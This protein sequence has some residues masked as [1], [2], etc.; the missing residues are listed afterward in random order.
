M[1]SLK[2]SLNLGRVTL[3]FQSLEDFHPDQLYRNFPALF[4]IPAQSVEPKVPSANLLDEIVQ[5]QSPAPLLSEAADLRAFLDRAVRPHLESR[6]DQH[7]QDHAAASAQHAAD[8]MSAILHHASFQSIEA[9]WQSLK[10]LIDRLQ[11]GTGAQIYIADITLAELRSGAEEILKRLGSNWQLIISDYRF[12]QTEPDVQLLTIFATHAQSIGAIFMAE[13]EPPA[14]DP[15]N[16][17][18]QKLRRSDVAHSVG[19][20]LPRFLLRLPYGKATSPIEGF[21]F[22]E[23][24][25]SVHADYLWGNPAF[26]CA[27]LLAHSFVSG[28]NERQIIG[29][30]QHLYREAGSLTAKPCAEI[31]LTEKDAEY[32]LDHGIMPLASLKGQDAVLVVRFQSIADPPTPL[33][34]RLAG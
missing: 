10:F 2:P 11:T 13:S 22:E 1:V 19:L 32:L 24:E 33:R 16:E 5:E 17:A 14:A 7:Q 3:T 6:P 15:S 21:P 23:M 31:L 26:A 18:W 12:G 30:P 27:Y 20:A 8:V 25:G 34:L 28:T 29:L 9:S 4:Q